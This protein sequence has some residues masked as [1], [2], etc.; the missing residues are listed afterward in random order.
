MRW[1]SCL[2][3]LENKDVRSHLSQ[4]SLEKFNRNMVGFLL[5]WMKNIHSFRLFAFEVGESCCLSSILELKS[6]VSNWLSF[7]RAKQF[8]EDIGDPLS[9]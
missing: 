8:P 2:I 4:A 9:Q 7:L 5:D 1:L 6:N 3:L